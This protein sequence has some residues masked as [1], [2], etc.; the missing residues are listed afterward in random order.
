MAEITA[1][2]TLPIKQNDE[3]FRLKLNEILTRT[4]GIITPLQFGDKSETD[5]SA[6]VADAIAY[7]ED[8][9]QTVFLP[10]VGAPWILDAL[11]SA[12]PIVAWGGLFWKANAQVPMLTMSESLLVANI[13]NGNEAN[14]GD[15]VTDETEMISVENATG[16]LFDFAGAIATGIPS[17]LLFTDEFS[18]NGRIMA[19]ALSYDCIGAGQFIALCC[20]GWQVYGLNTENV[21]NGDGW[22]VRVGHFNA[23]DRSEDISDTKIIAPRI[24]GNANGDQTSGSGILCELDA[25][26]TV[27]V[28]PTLKQ[29]YA[30]FKLESVAADPTCNTDGLTVTDMDCED[31][32]ATVNT[33]SLKGSRTHVT[34]TWRGQGI[35]EL[36]DDAY[37]NVDVNG[38]GITGDAPVKLRGPR[39]RVFGNIIN[40]VQDGVKIEPE[41]PNSRVDVY[42]EG[43]TTDCIDSAAEECNLKVI[44]N[45]APAAGIRLR[46]TATENTIAR[47]SFFDGATDKVAS[48]VTDGSCT[49]QRPGFLDRTSD[50][51]ST[52]TSNTNPV[53]VVHSGTLTGT[54]NLTLATT[55][56][57]YG[58]EFIIRRT[59]GG[60][61]NL[62]VKDPGGT[63]LATMATNDCVHARN[64]NGT[65]FIL[66]QWV[67][68]A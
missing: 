67:P 16:K 13:I 54:R 36:G 59:G 47:D 45:G 23:Q 51:N 60:A 61:F 11:T 19:P 30:A 14:N 15:A 37:W 33:F 34:G 55:G 57:G 9:G 22:V 35:A 49:Y 65:W 21:C 50:A 46:S 66:R 17:A 48:A 25:H 68:P 64:E 43:C 28:S 32:Y 12:A 8:T 44:V 24:V 63:T 5:D 26:D 1:D 10:N 29:L 53:N 2:R 4:A 42:V 20:K 3:L 40:P 58:A 31:L 18:A 52:L 41:A 39:A 38:G 7:A 6:T 56:S 62:L 27:V